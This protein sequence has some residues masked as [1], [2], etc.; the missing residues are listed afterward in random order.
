[1][2]ALF[3]PV[4]FSLLAFSFTAPEPARVQIDPDSR[5]EDVSAIGELPTQ[6]LRE[7]NR[8]TRRVE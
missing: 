3:L 1:M 4:A 6:A 7:Q 2:S 5:A 8:P